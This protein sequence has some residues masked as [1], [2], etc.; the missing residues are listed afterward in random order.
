MRDILGR[1]GRARGTRV[2]LDLALA[3]GL[4]DRETWLSAAYRGIAMPVTTG[5]ICDWAAIPR[6]PKAPT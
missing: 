1:E 5:G 3:R 2:V 6:Q 4:A